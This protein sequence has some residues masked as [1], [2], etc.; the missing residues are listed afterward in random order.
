MIEVI[1]S[2]SVRE[3]RDG[4]SGPE[5]QAVTDFRLGVTERDSGADAFRDSLLRQLSIYLAE[6]VFLDV[7]RVA[8]LNL[9]LL[10]GDGAL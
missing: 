7:V 8:E 1:L 3:V 6:T 2:W 9:D 5:V 4:V 10:A